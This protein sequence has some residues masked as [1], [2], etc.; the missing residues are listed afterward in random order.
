MLI[1]N[2]DISVFG[3]S[4]SNKLIQPTTIEIEKI[5]IK[6]SFNQIDSKKQFKKVSIKLLFEGENRDVINN[7]ISNF[8]S[9]LINEVDIKFKNLSH[10]YHV[11]IVDHNLEDT[12]FDEWL[13]LNIELVGYEYSTQ[14]VEA[15]NRITTKTINVPGNTETPAT[16][17]ITPSVSIIDIVL[18]GLSDEPMTI[19]N[20]TGGKKVI[21]D[22][23]EGIVTVDGV[24]KF[25][26][27]D[28]WE[29]PRLKSGA[30]TITVSRNNVDINIKYKPRFI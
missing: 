27:T 10:F 19:K 25:N 2:I 23:E 5:R 30:N 9:K 18:T 28:M 4:V 1:N 24:N 26:D 14:I 29:F 20:L 11:Y 7:N 6:N 12:D 3:A 21:I 17:E 13:Y 15:M 16:V 22:G 8:M